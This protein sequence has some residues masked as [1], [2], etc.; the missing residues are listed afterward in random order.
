MELILSMDSMAEEKDLVLYL[1]MPV[2]QRLRLTQRHFIDLQMA[3]RDWREADT[4]MESSL[5]DS[6][7]G[8][9]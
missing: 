1:D 2:H 9:R 7:I 6:D 5:R 8:L 3:I 4:N